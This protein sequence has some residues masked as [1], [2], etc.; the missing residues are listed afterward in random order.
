MCLGKAGATDLL[1]K[2]LTLESDRL[3][4]SYQLCDLG[5]VSHLTIQGFGSHIGK[6][7]RI[8]LPYRLVVKLD[9]ANVIAWH[10]A[11]RVVSA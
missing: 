2:N 7:G 8:L 3:G 4:S 1:V 9:V 6:M 11:W 10:N 5:Q